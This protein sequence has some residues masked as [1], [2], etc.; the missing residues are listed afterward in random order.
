MSGGGDLGLAALVAGGGER[1]GPA[2]REAAREASPG[3]GGRRGRTVAWPPPSPLTV[4][5]LVRVGLSL[6]RADRLPI[7][8]AVMRRAC[9]W[10]M[11]VVDGGQVVGLISD[12]DLLRAVADGLSTDVVVV[13]D[14]MRPAPEAVGVSVGVSDAAATMVRTGAPH[15]PVVRDGR[16][17]GVV[18]A[19]DILAAWG[20]PRGLLGDEPW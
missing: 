18:S 9:A 12:R 1:A 14:Y 2:A 8:A 11:A 7:A 15:L 13:A 16:L 3:R 5:D 6:E 20:V 19:R 4:G 17:L 10:A